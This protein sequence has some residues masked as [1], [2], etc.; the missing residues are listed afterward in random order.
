MEEQPPDLGLFQSSLKAITDS[1]SGVSALLDESC[2][3]VPE[4]PNGISLL[5][6]KN[7]LL[8]AYLHHL[9]LFTL[10]RVQGRSLNDGKA[11][12]DDSVNDAS[13]VVNGLV[14]NRIVLE[15][16][17][18][19]E[20]KLR[21]QIDKL[22]KKAENADRAEQEGDA[23]GDN[24]EEIG[25]DPLA[26][27]PNPLSLMTGSGENASG[28]ED[29]DDDGK[30]AAG[31]KSSGSGVYRPPRL[32]PVAYTEG[33]KDKKERRPPAGS[34]LLRDM[35][36]SLTSANPYTEST[37]GL[38]V[39]PSMQSRKARKLA[40][41]ERYEEDNMTRIFMTK[42]DSKRRRMD[43]ED[44]ALGGT[45]SREDFLVGSKGVRGKK[46][47]GFENEFDDLL[48]SIGK[49]RKTGAADGY[50]ALRAMR[51][52]RR[53]AAGADSELVNVNGIP[54]EPSGKGG[55]AKKGKFENA[56]RRARP[57]NS[58]GKPSQGARAKKR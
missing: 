45:G 18:P 6:L 3:E 35:A 58:G 5:G 42:K 28:S 33:K 30:A 16:I 13:A 41:I 21:Y 40:E 4:Y 56:M 10:C 2:K 37:S 34:A 46:S 52:E 32:A 24:D 36:T 31:G 1:A 54:S 26:F 43:E 38:G 51:K 55:K 23:N 19:L 27:K 49:K 44:I 39:T 11:G 8:L 50:D 29:E 14:K 9:T 57:S 15:K 53:P 22:V 7:S 47:S 25:N 12:E 17:K 20:V 48:G